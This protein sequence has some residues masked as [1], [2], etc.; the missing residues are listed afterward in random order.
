FSDYVHLTRYT[1]S[2]HVALPISIIEWQMGECV[3]SHFLQRYACLS[4]D[5]PKPRMPASLTAYAAFRMGYCKMAAGAMRGTEEEPRLQRSEEHTS[6]LQSPYD[7]V[8]RL[9]L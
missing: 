2:L 5:D 8:C 7:L 1:L 6:E 9:L 3:A 4:G